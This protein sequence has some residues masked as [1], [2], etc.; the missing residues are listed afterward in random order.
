MKVILLSLILLMMVA[1]PCMAIDID[2][3]NADLHDTIARPITV[4]NDTQKKGWN[5]WDTTLLFLR[6][7]DWGQTR[8][9]ATKT[10]KVIIGH[11]SINNIG[12]I[13][14]EYVYTETNPI[15]GTHP[16]LEKVDTYFVCCMGC[17]YLIAKYVSPKLHK[18][19]DVIGIVLESYCVNHNLQTEVSFKF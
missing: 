5:N 9:I 17:D 4:D 7:A 16:S 12:I 3:V 15:L 18:C 11:D 8:D 6:V 13:E 19:W 10:Q 2:R 14:E 1:S